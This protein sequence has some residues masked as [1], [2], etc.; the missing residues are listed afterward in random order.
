MFALTIPKPY[1]APAVSAKK[2][3]SIIRPGLKNI[4]PYGTSNCPPINN[5]K[6]NRIRPKSHQNSAPDQKDR[7]FPL[8]GNYT[9]RRGL[10]LLFSLSI[11]RPIEQNFLRKQ[12]PKV[13][14]QFT[15]L[16]LPTHKIAL[17]ELARCSSQ[18]SAGRHF[19]FCV[20]P[21]VQRKIQYNYNKKKTWYYG[22]G[23]GFLLRIWHRN[24]F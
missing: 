14:K 21:P 2:K 5:K 11:L 16:K 23:Y 12:F 17:P 10:G 22:S 8:P 15:F 7:I 13:Q 9:L 4:I 6:G 20:I 1:W 24:I 18:A 19:H 3:F